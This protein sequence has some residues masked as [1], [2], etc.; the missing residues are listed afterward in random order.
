MHERREIM[1]RKRTA[2]G[3]RVIRTINRGSVKVALKLRKDTGMYY[4]KTRLRGRRTRT[5]LKTTSLEQAVE[6]ATELTEALAAEVDRIGDQTYSSATRHLTLGIAFDIFRAEGLPM[7]VGSNH[8]VNLDRAMRVAEAVL[9]RG[10][11][12]REVDQVQLNRFKAARAEGGFMIA[13]L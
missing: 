10:M 5:S 11:E 13:Q 4:A 7:H 3:A 2:K 12:L 6:L 1:S 8:W 9:G